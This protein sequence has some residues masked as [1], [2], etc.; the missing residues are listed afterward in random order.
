MI[1]K[2]VLS[3]VDGIFFLSVS[4]PHDLEAIDSWMRPA[5]EDQDRRLALEAMPTLDRGEAFF[6]QAHKKSGALMKFR[7]RS[8]LTFDSS[9]T[10]TV[11]DPEPPTPSLSKISQE[12][13]QEVGRRLRKNQ[14]SI[15]DWKPEVDVK[16]P[17]K[18]DEDGGRLED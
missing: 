4:A 9:R 1:S 5:V 14:V 6:V 18:D 3:Q 13:W 7:T 11:D 15:L 2:N 16:F 12:R 17:T 10:P 8:K